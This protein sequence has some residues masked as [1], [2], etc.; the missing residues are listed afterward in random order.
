MLCKTKDSIHAID[1]AQSK[2]GGFSEEVGAI[3]QVLDPME[4][5]TLSVAGSHDSRQ[6]RQVQSMIYGLA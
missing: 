3:T 5:P 4:Y 6:M 1:Q 2:Q